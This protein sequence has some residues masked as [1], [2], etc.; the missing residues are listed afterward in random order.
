MI[1]AEAGEVVAVLQT[2]M[3]AG[4]PYWRLRDA[5]F[6]HPTMAEGLDP[7]FSNLQPG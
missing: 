5:I 4:L 6:A 3:L 1:C 7:L 2:A